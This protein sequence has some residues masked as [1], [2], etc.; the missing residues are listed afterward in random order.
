[1]SSI[2]LV[3]GSCVDQKVDVVVNA[4]NRS[5]VAGAGLCGAIFSRAGY[6]ELTDACPL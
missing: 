6:K 4:A 1:M 5:L 2:E 3:Y